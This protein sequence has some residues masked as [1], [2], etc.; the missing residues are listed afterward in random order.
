MRGLGTAKL[1][2]S[3]D[4]FLVNRINPSEDSNPFSF[5]DLAHGRD[6]VVLGLWFM[7]REAEMAGARASDLTLQGNEVSLTIPVHKTDHRGRFTQRTLTC[8][9][10]SKPHNLCVWHSAE[11]HLLRLEAHPYRFQGQGFPLFPDDQG[12]TASKQTFIDVI[13]RVIA[14]TGTATTRA[15]PEGQESQRFSG[16]VLRIAGAQMMSS[17]GVELALIQ[18]LG[19]WTSTAVLRY[20][21]DSALVRVPW[22]PQQVLSAQ[23]TPCQ[24]VQMGMAPQTPMPPAAEPPSSTSRSARPKAFASAVRSIQA[25]MEQIKQ[26]LSK[27][28]ETYVFRPKAKILHRASKYESANEPSKWRTPCGWNYGSRTF[29]RTAAIEDGA[30]KCRKCFDLSDDS[31]SESGESSSGLSDIGLSSASSAEDSD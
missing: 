9:C 2:D 26:A 12:R 6:M 21:Q 15:G 5:D 28:E 8:S 17:S 23:E 20:T 10:G 31:S 18:L 25:E 3:F 16:H 24:R 1:K 7:L 19:R 4:A 22:I 14:S 29:L 13:R 11:R 27:P 30:R